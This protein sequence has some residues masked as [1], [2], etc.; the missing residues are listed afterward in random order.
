MLKI[1]FDTRSL[2]KLS[3]EIQDFADTK[4]LQIAADTVEKQ[5]KVL[6]QQQGSDSLG[7]PFKPYTKPY[8]EQRRRK[9]LQIARVDLTVTGKY[10]KSIGLRQ[11]GDTNYVGPSDELQ[12]QAKGLSKKRTH[13]E[14]HPDTPRNVE[15]SL[16]KAWDSII[17]RG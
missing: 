14:L 4:P 10:M 7:E 8:A 15:F 9:G 11:D 6:S 12:G 3:K 5:I 13:L 1:T 16:K 2:A 17:G